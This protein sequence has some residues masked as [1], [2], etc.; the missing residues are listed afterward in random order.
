MSS[1][2]AVDGLLRRILPAH[3]ADSLHELRLPLVSPGMPRQVTDALVA[4]AADGNAGSLPQAAPV[5]PI[6]AVPCSPTLLGTSQHEECSGPG[7]LP[8]QGRCQGSCQPASSCL[9][10]GNVTAAGQGAGPSWDSSRE[11]RSLCCK[12]SAS[13]H[14]LRSAAPEQSGLEGPVVP[15]LFMDFAT[16]LLTVT[17]LLV[18]LSR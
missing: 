6:L 12:S 13:K 4:S 14:K 3:I 1:W 2:Q 10:G 18:L 9:A 17:P 7:M 8:T 5:L 16:L 11:D 15:R